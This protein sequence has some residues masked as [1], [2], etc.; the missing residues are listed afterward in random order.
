MKM[1]GKKKNKTRNEVEGIFICGG[2]GEYVNLFL[3]DTG[4]EV[5]LQ[6]AG[7]HSS[8][9]H[10]IRPTYLVLPKEYML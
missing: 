4:C 8:R 3:G 5:G 1:T 10:F 2:W 7:D 6:E 9:R